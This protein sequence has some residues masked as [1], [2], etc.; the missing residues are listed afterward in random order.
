M[1][2]QRVEWCSREWQHQTGRFDPFQFADEKL[3]TE[4]SAS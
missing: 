1:A 2:L 3:M 4:I